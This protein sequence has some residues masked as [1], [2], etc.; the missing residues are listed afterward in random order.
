MKNTVFVKAGKVAVQEID[1]P[2]IQADD[3]VI[4]H[5]VRTCVCGSDLW[6]YRGLQDKEPNSQNTGHEAIGIVEEV[7][8]A[9]TTVAPGDF[10][11]APFSHGC[12]HCA[13]CL[14]GF[15]G[16]CQN[17]ADNYSRGFQAEFVRFQNA[18]WAL[19][20]IPGKPCKIY[21]KGMNEKP[22]TK[23]SHDK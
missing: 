23:W 16:S 5:V 17:H 14:A 3:D 13:A 12:G 9:I 20:K 8:S 2:T 18:E 21:V 6:S 22:G 19:V 7:G 15:D 11:I 10:V 4:I 1:K